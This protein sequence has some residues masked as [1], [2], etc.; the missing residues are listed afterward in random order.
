[1]EGVA[2]HNYFSIDHP[3][4]KEASNFVQGMQRQRNEEH[5]Q[6]EMYMSSRKEQME[7]QKER[8]AEMKEL[9]R[10]ERRTKLKEYYQSKL[11]QRLEEKA[12]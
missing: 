11:Q 6:Y 8:E 9:E 10:M 2:D 4:T 12:I 3:R 7:Y 1:M 5:K